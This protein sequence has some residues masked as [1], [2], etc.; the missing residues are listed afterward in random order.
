MPTSRRQVGRDRDIAF[1]GA[2]SAPAALDRGDHLGRLVRLKRCLHQRL[3]RNGAGV[4]GQRHFGGIG[5]A[6]HPREKLGGVDEV[7]TVLPHVGRDAGRQ[8]IEIGDADRPACRDAELA[9]RDAEAR[10]AD[11]FGDTAGFRDPGVHPLGEGG[12]ETGFAVARQHQHRLGPIRHEAAKPRHAGRPRVVGVDGERIEPFRAHAGAHA[13]D[14][15]GEHRLG[16]LALRPGDQAAAHRL[17]PLT[18]R[19]RRARA[20]CE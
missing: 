10:C 12:D 4:S 17:P 20:A 15:G 13:L 18:R 16:Q 11:D 9:G 19:S 7:R 8:A 2:L 6:A 14:P 1:L 5:A 3:V